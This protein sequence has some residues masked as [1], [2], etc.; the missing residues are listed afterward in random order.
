MGLH[1][2]SMPVPDSLKPSLPKPRRPPRDATN[3]VYDDAKAACSESSSGTLNTLWYHDP[4]CQAPDKK[5]FEAKFTADPKYA[6]YLTNVS[7]LADYF[8]SPSTS[9]LSN[10]SGL[11]Q[12][13]PR[14]K[15][16]TDQISKQEMIRQENAIKR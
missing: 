12:N 15:R 11:V 5:T 2:S 4:D 8:A 16:S 3:Q 7:Q 13:K 10:I 9:E 14:T 1:R 6:E